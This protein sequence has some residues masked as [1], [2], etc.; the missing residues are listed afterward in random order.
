MGVI[1]DMVPRV[2]EALSVDSSYDNEI[3]PYGI[4]RAM[5]RFL[6]DYNFPWSLKTETFTGLVAGQRSYE[7][8]AG[9]KKEL[10][11]LFYDTTDE[12]YS[13]P[14]LKREG[15]VLPY[16]DGIPRHYWMSDGQLHTDIALAAADAATTNLVL[17]YQSLDWAENEE[18]MVDRFEDMLFTFA[19]FRLAAEKNKKEVAEIYGALWQDDRQSLA[20]YLNELE[21]DNQIFIQREAQT[22][23]T[24]RYG[25]LSRG[26]YV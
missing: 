26:P 21:F 9:F 3:I 25:T 20:I 23:H 22:V 6:R 17:Y 4:Q 18:W 19:T 11:V 13:D 10:G 7:L 12:T 5:T 2:R 15:F 1:A 16:S 14:L 24:D 8:P